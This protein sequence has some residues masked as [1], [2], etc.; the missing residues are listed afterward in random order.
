MSDE[1]EP[2]WDLLPHA[3]EE[4]FGLPDD[5]DVR[6]LKRSYNRLIRRFKPEKFPE[7]F[8]RI[9]GAYESLNDARRYGIPSRPTPPPNVPPQDVHHNESPRDPGDRREAAEPS[10]PSGS[11]PAEAERQEPAP[12]SP[13]ER[14]A[15]T[16][17]SVLYAELHARPARTSGDYIMLAFLADVVTQA[18]APDAENE[19]FAG[20]LLAGLAE[21]PH[22]WGLTELLRDYLCQELPPAEIE[23]LL[24]RAVEAL[25]T[26]RFQYVTERAWD[27]LLRET[28]FEQF[29]NCLRQCGDRLGRSIDVT[30]LVFYVHILKQALWKADDEFLLDLQQTVEDHYDL[31]DPWVQ[32]EFELIDSLIAYRE[33]RDEF[34]SCGPCCRR[35][36]RAIQDWCLLDE[37]EGDRSVLGCQYYLSMR[38]KRILDELPDWEA[39]FSWVLIPWEQIVDDVLDR[40]GEPDPPP[41]SSLEEHARDF[42]IR[43]MRRR[44]RS[45]QYNRGLMVAVTALALLVVTVFAAGAFVVRMFWKLLAAGQFLG[46][47][48]DLLLAAATLVGGVIVS[49]IIFVVSYRTTRLRYETVRRELIKLIRVAPI[50]LG[51]LATIIE[52]REDEEYGEGDNI[53]STGVVA[54]KLQSDAALELFSQAQICLNVA[55]AAP[56]DEAELVENP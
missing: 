34:T 6:D 29:R 54:E 37:T 47:L 41:E 3:P 5:Y 51:Q 17:A 56:V 16:P 25:P 42:M 44:E 2:R 27:R 26:D 32:G 8:Q 35:I 23:Q 19:S 28:P 24:L 55:D 52:E 9:R 50:P 15:T 46:A 31:L 14:I 1:P 33:R 11:S 22:D 10:P 12:P 4:F 18:A 39:D 13:R 45:P 43:C 49:L 36:D 38:G 30:E 48:F 21:H 20:W 7:E 40:L 53:A